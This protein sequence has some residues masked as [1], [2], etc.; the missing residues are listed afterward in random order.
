MS[1][2]KQQQQAE[3]HG[4]SSWE[5]RVHLPFQWVTPVPTTVNGTFVNRVLLSCSLWGK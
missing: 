3:V 1:I 5:V 4:A 2:Q